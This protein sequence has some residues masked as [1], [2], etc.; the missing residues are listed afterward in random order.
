MEPSYKQHTAVD[1]QAGIIVDVQVTT[2]EASE[3]RQLPK[4][5]ERIEAQTGIRIQ[6]ATA[7]GAYAHSA[8]F[9][10]L[11]RGTPGPSSRRNRRPRGGP[12]PRAAIPVRRAS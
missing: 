9:A 6:T 10:L 7:D 11:E 2:G 4:Q 8:N 1:D 5:I 12:A 3:G